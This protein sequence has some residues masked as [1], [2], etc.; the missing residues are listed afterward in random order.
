VNP[1]ETIIADFTGTPLAGQSATGDR[2]FRELL[3]TADGFGI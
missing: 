2:N 1:T 3:F